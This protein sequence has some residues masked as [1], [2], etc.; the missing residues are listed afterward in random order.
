MAI[1]IECPVCEF[2][3]KV[4][5]DQQGRETV[6]KGCGHK[7]T[8]DGASAGNGSSAGTI[9]TAASTVTTTAK[10]ATAEFIAAQCPACKTKGRVPASARGKKIKCP[11]CSESFIVGQIEQPAPQ[12]SGPAARL[13]DADEPPPP[14][15]PK[16][17][18]P[19]PSKGLDEVNAPEDV[20]VAPL[21]G[22][23]I[24]EDQP[25]EEVI[26]LVG[27][28]AIIVETICPGCKHKGTVPEKFKGK[29]VKCPRCSVMF[30]IGGSPPPSLAVQSENPFAALDAG[31]STPLKPS[32]AAAD[33]NPF[34]FEESAPTKPTAPAKQTAAAPSAI[35]PA[36]ETRPAPKSKPRTK[37]EAKIEEEEARTNMYMMAAAGGFVLLAVVIGGIVLVRVLNAPGAKD[38]SVAVV[39]PTERDEPRVAGKPSERDRPKEPEVKVKPPDEAVIRPELKPDSKTDPK[40][41]PKIDPKT[42]PKGQE[43][44]MPPPIR[45]AKEPTWVDGSRESASIGDLR[46]RVTAA[47]IDF[48]KG[49]GGVSPRKFLMV[50]VQIENP[51]A[52]KQAA[53]VGWGVPDVIAGKNAPAKLIDPVGKELKLATQK[54]TVIKPGGQ[55]TR[56]FIMPGQALDDLLVFEPAMGPTP[57]Y[58]RLELPAENLGGQ[59]S[60]GF[61][62][63]AAM[64]SGSATTKDP[65]VKNEAPPPDKALADKLALLRQTA[66]KGLPAQ[67]ENAIKTLGELGANAAPAVPDLMGYLRE[68]KN[69]MVRAASAEAL[70]KI[71]PPAKIAINTLIAALR[72]E[73]WRVKANSCEALAVF[74]PDAKDAIPMLKKLM[75][76]KEEEVPTKA[77]L[78]LSRIEE[79]SKGGRP[80]AGPPPKGLPPTPGVPPP[81]GLPKVQG[82]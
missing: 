30:V 19:P 40:S 26:D 49:A 63:P 32:A 5:D 22:A 77:A 38:T 3:G 11:K 53:Y 68:D 81:P 21:E 2:Q 56:E 14:D 62:L 46:V 37:V 54:E 67:R 8:L 73:F 12:P 75:T 28:E 55:L 52:D 13:Q 6:C 82:N 71:G 41:D 1:A 16:T 78:A 48:P 39:T 70:G 17:Y 20:G 51:S 36:A 25:K 58:M 79:R 15:E 34:A 59:G 29:K 50:Q 27:D 80:K 7:W 23:E 42:E 60:I 76:S 74:G 10:P 35:K 65:L 47:W 18:T 61:Q 4:A 69:E 66:K 43:P 64:V 24:V 72:D 57:E 44:P 31:A 9:T 33:A 45:Q